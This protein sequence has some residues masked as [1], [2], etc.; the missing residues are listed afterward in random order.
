[1]W[2]GAVGDPATG[3]GERWFLGMKFRGPGQL[4]AREESFVARGNGELARR[5]PPPPPGPMVCEVWKRKQP[6]LDR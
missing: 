2:L 6:P 5:T 4:K 3:S 1:M